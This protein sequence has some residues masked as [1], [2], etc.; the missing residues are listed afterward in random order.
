MK[1]FLKMKLK[2]FVEGLR[3]GYAWLQAG[4]CRQPI[5]RPVAVSQAVIVEQMRG[6]GLAVSVYG[7]MALIRA[8]HRVKT[9]YEYK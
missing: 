6:N 7:R 1:R 4:I 5:W 9:M 8:Q 2:L 3:T